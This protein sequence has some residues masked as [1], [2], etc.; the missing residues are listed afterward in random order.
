MEASPIS[1]A[2]CTI[3]ARSA[4]D[5]CIGGGGGGGGGNGGVDK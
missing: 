1:P 4:F 5:A 3:Q 2:G